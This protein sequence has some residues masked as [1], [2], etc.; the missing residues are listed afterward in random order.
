MKSQICRRAMHL[1]AS[2]LLVGS[3]AVN[4]GHA[5]ATIPDKD[6]DGAADSPLI[7]RY[8]GSHIVSYDKKVYGEL[9]L[10]L[11]ALKASDN[12]DERDAHNNRVYRPDVAEDVAGTITRLAYVLPEDRSPLEVL[13]NYQDEIEASG[14]EVKFEC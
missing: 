4:P 14:G 10:P 13:R 2:V 7:K 9:A 11:A 3:L 6:I 8:E 12:P 1:T 5:D